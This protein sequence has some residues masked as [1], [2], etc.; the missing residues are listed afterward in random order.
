MP[1]NSEMHR[2]ITADCSYPKEIDD[3]LFIKPLDEDHE[4]YQVGVCIADTSKIYDN[5][6]VTKQ[7]FART[8]ARYWDLPDG[9]RGYDPMID[10]KLVQKIE[11]KAGTVR[12]AMVASFMVGVHE[13]PS[14]IEISFEPVKIDKNIDYRQLSNFTYSEQGRKYL[15]AS[16]LIRQHLGYIAYGDHIGSRPQWR[17]DEAGQ[18]AAVNM[19]GRAWKRGSQI[20]E[21]F[22]VATNH[23]VGKLMD[24][25]NRPVIYRVHDPDDEQYL[26][27]LSASVARFSRKA[28]LH[29]GLGLD[30][31]CRVT[32]P[33]R[34][35]DDF[36]SI[37]QLRQ[38]DRGLAPTAKDIQD[39]AFAVRRLN[40]EL[41][42]SAPKEAARLSR[43]DI[44]GRA[45][46]A[47]G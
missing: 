47:A 12:D 15:R 36:V 16:L 20:N 9:E 45:A 19:S 39:V 28:G 2:I 34:R 40:Q 11:L 30:P 43:R 1:I 14:D 24:E 33:L 31:Y 44:L 18:P 25:E 22:M 38:R 42:A 32:S 7:A 5:V 26:E 4:L 6:E 29:S 8:T 41:V 37:Q 10:P 35:L 13:A 23:L 17:K 21:S 46:L 3:G 27:L